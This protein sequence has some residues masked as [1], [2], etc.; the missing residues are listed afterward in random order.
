VD[1]FD[2]CPDQ[3]QRACLLHLLHALVTPPHSFRVVVASCLEYDIR[4]TCKQPLLNSNTTIPRL[5]EYEVSG[6]FYQYLS[7]EFARIRSNH[8]A[9]Q[10]IPAKWP[11]QTT[12]HTLRTSR[13][14]FG[15]IL[16]QSS[17]MLTTPG[18]IQLSCSGMFSMPHRLPSSLGRR[19]GHIPPFHLSSISNQL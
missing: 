8:P 5:E 18:A 12:L 17:N 13:Q 2:E 6:E 10:S 14:A 16:L 9:K 1:G 15:P 11:G 4:T 3:K 7:D 19:T